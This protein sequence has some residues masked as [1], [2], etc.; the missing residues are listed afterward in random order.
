MDMRAILDRLI[1]FETVSHMTNVPL[2]RYVEGLLAEAGIAST[3]IFDE[4]GEKANLYAR[5]GPED[6]PGVVLSGHVDV[7]PVEGQAWTRPPFALTQEGD[8]L[9]GRGTTDMK[10]FDACAIVCMLNA[11]KRDLKVPLILAL[12]HDEEIG[13]RGVGSM[14]D[15]MAEWPV[16]PRL[17]IIGEP[18]SMEAAIGHKG[19]I[20]LRLS[21]T[22]RG[23]HSSAAPNALNAIH[24]ATDFIGA[25]R[26]L[27]AEVATSGPFD[28]DYGVPYTTLHVG[29]INGGVQVNVVA[30]AC[31]IDMEIRSLAQDDPAR[32]I[33]RL[34]AEAEAIVVPL[35]ADFPEAAIEVER[36]WD[37]PGLGTAPD[38]DVVSFV[39]GLTGGNTHVKVAFGTEGGMF[40]QRLGLPTVVCGPGAMTQGH[41][42]DEYVEIA[43]LERCEAMLD[44]L[45]ARC[46]AGF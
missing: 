28:S 41:M 12:S 31:V 35:R 18:T 19:K 32:L 8:R 25:V 4:T 26:E 40:A 17:C 10:G 27:Q 29:K 39:K 36:L 45:L 6:V 16:Q 23:G 22:G 2:M 46:E 15:A 21:C 42:P 7:V 24:L 20:A 1:G 13:C 34:K 38:A 33:E 5:V 44:A 30:N 11:A 43:Q 14:I 37:Y 9:Y 3:L